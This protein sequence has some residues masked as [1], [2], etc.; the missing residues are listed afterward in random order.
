MLYFHFIV[1]TLWRPKHAQ[2]DMYSRLKSSLFFSLFD[3]PPLWQRHTLPRRPP[4]QHFK[5]SCQNSATSTT[6]IL[7]YFWGRG[8]PSPPPNANFCTSNILVSYSPLFA[9]PLISATCA[10]HLSPSPVF[11][12]VRRPQAQTAIVSHWVWKQSRGDLPRPHA[13]HV[14]PHVQEEQQ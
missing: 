14:S 10:V 8:E 4:S 12:S 7:R 5:S 3:T 6:T 2:T 1:V 9:A 11:S 13:S